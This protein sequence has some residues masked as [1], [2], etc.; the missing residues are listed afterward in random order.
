M[1][2]FIDPPIQ[3]SFR[4]EKGR[5]ETLCT[6][7]EFCGICIVNWIIFWFLGGT[8][9]GNEFMC[10]QELIYAAEASG[11]SWSPIG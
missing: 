2:K 7:K 9:N 3:L 5:N 1:E 11:L 6:T 10:K 8:T 4:Q